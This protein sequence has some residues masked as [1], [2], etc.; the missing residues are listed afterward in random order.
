MITAV[1]AAAGLF[2][3]GFYMGVNVDL[4]KYLDGSQVS[5]GESTVVDNSAPNGLKANFSLFW[6]TVDIVKNRYYKADEIKDQDLL[7]GAIKGMVGS[8]GDP[9]TDF[10]P[11]KDA[12]KFEEDINGVFGGIG[13]EIGIRKNQLVIVSPLKGNPAEAAGLKAGDQI[14][15]VDDT[16][17]NSLT[18]DDAVKIIRGEPGVPVR[19]LIMRENWDKP[20]EF[21]IVRQV[22]R[23]PTLDWDMKETKAGRVAYIQLYSFNT[24][25]PSLFYDASFKALLNG[26]KGLILDLRDNPGGFLEVANN[27]AGWFL[28]KGQVIVKERFPNDKIDN[29]FAYGSAAWNKLPVVVLVNGG[30]ASASEILAGALRDQLG[31]K[32]VGEKTFGKGTVQEVESL[33]DGST[34]KV[35]IA[36]WLT[37]SGKEINDVGLEPDVKVK[38]T[39][40]DFKAGKD[41][42]FDAA[43][44]LI[45]SEIRQ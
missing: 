10:F 45:E 1:L 37:P 17:T 27:L 25:A 35:S 11:P 15:K 8:L 19:L 44:K 29:F 21:K 30:S 42:Q 36:E 4:S 9:Y 43:L 6:N 18:L 26:A 2:Y 3:F 5:S 24:N 12:K 13:A 41:P 40:E 20:K 34:L 23:V 32:L 33:P 22:I 38:L 14:L 31:V 16:F 28:E 39:E 7:Y